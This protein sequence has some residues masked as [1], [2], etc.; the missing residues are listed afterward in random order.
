MN[1]IVWAISP[2]HDSLLDLTRRMRRHAEEVF[3]FR[4]V[5]LD[6]QA[7]A[8]EIELRLSV[9]TRRDLLLIFKEAVSNAAKHSSCTEVQVEFLCEDSVLKLR[10]KDNGIGFDPG[11]EN[12]GNGLGSMKRRA[13]ALGGTFLIESR[14]R[15]GTLVEFEARIP[16][17]GRN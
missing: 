10:V 9:G 14:D 11:F 13:T 2:D 15:D 1:D 5:A 16:K 6:F 3:A 4:D 7:P 12:D 17:S 8:P